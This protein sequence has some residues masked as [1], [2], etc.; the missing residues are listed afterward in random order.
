MAK[1][2]QPS[3]DRPGAGLRPVVPV[4]TTTAAAGAFRIPKLSDVMNG[5]LPLPGSAMFL[6]VCE[7]GLPLLMDVRDRATGSLLIVGDADRASARL[8]EMML[9]SASRTVKPG[10]LRLDLITE[11]PENLINALCY[12][13]TGQLAHPEDAQAAD[14]IWQHATLASR[15]QG[16]A[17]G[18]PTWLLVI[19]D[20]ENLS[21]RLDDETLRA[22]QWLVEHGPETHNRVLATFFADRFEFI[23]DRL[24]NA[25]RTRLVGYIPPHAYAEYLSGLRAE[26]ATSL[27]PG[28]EYCAR[29]S[30]ELV[31]FWLPENDV[32]ARRPDWVVHDE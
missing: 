28:L 2:V 31:R 14:M 9:T 13:V 23:D 5:L 3:P 21:H 6:G 16:H 12:P 29:I 15:R 24:L 10:E 17:A 32:P 25:F 30:G 18:H 20:L 22:L 27:I 11:N 7:D 4:R 19:D 8:L 26:V 1:L